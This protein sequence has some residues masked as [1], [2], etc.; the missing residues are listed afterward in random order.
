MSTTV[1]MELC[2]HGQ[3]VE[4]L[5]LAWRKEFT[6]ATMLANMTCLKALD[7]SLTNLTAEGCR[8]LAKLYNLVELDL[9]A[10]AIGHEGILCVFPS[11]NSSNI[12]E[13]RLRFVEGLASKTLVYLEKNAPKLRLLDITFSGIDQENDKLAIRAL[14]LKGITILM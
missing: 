12:E 2:R 14:Q 4:R 5:N 6:D 8:P 3:N 9:S 11:N 7:V 1:L 13:L 10:T